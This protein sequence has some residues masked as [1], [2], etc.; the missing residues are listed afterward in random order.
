MQKSPFKFLDSFTKEDSKIFFGRDKEIEE[1]YSRVFES[2]I[3]L[4]YGISGT[5]KSSLLNCGLANKFN[6][7]D[8]LPISVR[9]GSDINKSLID[10]LYKHALTKGPF[11]RPDKPISLA[12]ALQSIYLDHFKPIYLI[13]D[14]FEEVFI[15]NNKAEKDELIKNVKKIIDSEIQC[16]FIF[17][18][19]EEYLAG[20]TEFEKVIPSIL[21]NRIRIE[22]MTHHNAIQAIEGPC[23][24]NDIEVE[25]GFS[26]LLLEKLNPNSA[27]VE[28]TF[29]QV[30]LDKVYKLSYAEG[31]EKQIITKEIL[32][33]IGDVKD[34]LGAFLEEQISELEDPE[35]GLIVLKS[36]VSVKGTKLQITE[37][38]VIAN[39]K[40]FG[41]EIDHDQLRNIIQ[42][43]IGLRILRDK[44]E[45]GRYELR[46]DSLAA[47]IY[48]KISFV[49]K[50]LLEIR[51]FID[52]AYANFEKRNTYLS[53]EDLLYIAPY[54]DKLFLNDKMLRFLSVSKRII[55]KAKRR[56]QNIFIV[57]A[58][59]IFAILFSFSMWAL[60]EKGIAQ[61]L[62]KIAEVQKNKA[63]KA[64]VEAEVARQEAI[65]SKKIAEQNEYIALHAKTQSELDRK[66]ALL[67]KENALSQKNRA[68]GLSVVAHDQ[69]LKAEN[70]KR[71]ANQEKNK[72]EK[73]EE[74]TRQLSMLS[75]AQTL[76]LKS[77]LLDKNPQLMGL[78]AVQSYNFN[79]NNGG[80]SNDPIIYLAL[81]NS[82]VNLDR[83]KHSIYT[84]SLNE[85]KTLTYSNNSLQSVDFDGVVREWKTDGASVIKGS[86]AYQTSIVHVNNDILKNKII[87]GYANSM[88]LIWDATQLG[89]RKVAPIKL[90]GHTGELRALATTSNE[91]ILATAAKDSVMLIWNL[92]SKQP[93]LLQKFKTP[94]PVKAILFTNNE[95][96][97]SAQENGSLLYWNIS[98][99]TYTV[100]YKSNSI[101]PLSL[102]LD[103]NKE[104]LY[105]GCSNGTLLAYNLSKSITNPAK[106]FVVHTSG[107]DQIVFNKDY[108]MLATSSW[109]KSIKFY[110][111]SAYFEKENSTEK[112]IELKNI[113]SRARV[114]LFN[115]DNKLIAGMSDKTIHVWETSSSKLASVVGLMINRNMTKEEWKETI[116]DDIPY[117]K[118]CIK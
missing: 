22:K 32:D 93:I 101:K 26:E 49:E 112:A 41:S 54:E 111:Y 96:I 31:A 64:Q 7:A 91:K 76:A 18:I 55:S 98:K 102:A 95:T 97:I 52:N 114:I 38:E 100:M 11:E 53:E 12:K 117:E 87:V 28:L 15:F 34:L 69:A 63:I 17:S 50:E 84:G 14:Q 19:R 83:A 86:V 61:D 6:D 24:V 67:A 13:F 43:F 80:D 16:K 2:K 1:L 71:K 57:A 37:E 20:I 25:E 9:R 44:D 35:T 103:K 77:S 116:G 46:H 81:H 72:A 106:T 3:L 47:K 45:S 113:K 90:V 109:D 105:V 89:Q 33:K 36:F 104:M 108:S 21:L 85:C 59:I 23:R 56:R 65:E 8:W 79:K 82:Y 68:E 94:S 40:T 110:H 27:E 78:L 73:A 118:T 48:E 5:G 74:K 4:V 99:G 42:K 66:E 58:S 75:I 115:D 60:H 88:V 29:L 39:T 92:D 10:G 51:Q 70:E 30:F 107:V 62:Q